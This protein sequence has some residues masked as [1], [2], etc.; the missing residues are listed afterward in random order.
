MSRLATLLVHWNAHSEWDVVEVPQL[1]SCRKECG[2]DPKNLE[3][4]IRSICTWLGGQ[5]DSSEG[6]RLGDGEGTNL[7]Q[8]L[9][10]P[11]GVRTW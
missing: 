8:R 10:S 6:E 3:R 2:I 7:S 1:N 5:R 9:T 11:M 4:L